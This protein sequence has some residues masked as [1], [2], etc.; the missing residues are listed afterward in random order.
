MET[1]GYQNKMKTLL[2]LAKHPSLADSVRECLNSEHYKVVHRFGIEEAEPL[3]VH[4]LIQG[5]IIDVDMTD[6]QGIW[7]IEKLR[8]SLPHCPIILFAEPNWE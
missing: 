4:G 7:M 2:V 6:V 1:I 5:C 8:R 3:L